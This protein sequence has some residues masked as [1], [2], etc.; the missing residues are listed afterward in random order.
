MSSLEIPAYFLPCIMPRDPLKSVPFEV[1]TTRAGKKYSLDLYRY[2]IYGQGLVPEQLR[3]GDILFSNRAESL[4][5]IDGD[6]GRPATY[7]LKKGEGL[8]ELLDFARGLNPTAAAQKMTLQRFKSGGQI[9][10][11]DLAAPQE[12]LSGK[13]KM[14]LQDGDKVT[15]RKSM[16]L[17]ANFLTISGPV[18]YPGTYPFESTPTL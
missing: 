12:Y 17:S 4:V 13:L 2:L 10:F 16:E 5:E 14:E 11:V 18:N 6:V 9:D 8:K 1:Y 3:D 7:E 15:I